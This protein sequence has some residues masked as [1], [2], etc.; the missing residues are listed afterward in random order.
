VFLDTFF[1]FNR[2][3]TNQFYISLSM[4]DFAM[5]T[6]GTAFDPLDIAA[7]SG[8]ADPIVAILAL[9]KELWLIGTLTTEVWQGTGAADFYFQLVQGAYIQHGCIAPFTATNQDVLGFW[10]MQDKDGKNIVVQGANYEL[11]II[12]TPYLTKEFNSYETTADAIGF[13]FQLDDH[14]FYALTFPTGNK[15]WLYDLTTEQWAEWS[16][17]MLMMVHLIV[18][19]PMGLFSLTIKTILVI[20]KMVTFTH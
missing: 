11:K 7:K 8:S 10:L 14:A 4:A 6:G 1:V 5:L 20:E 12:S 3:A 15:T 13:T 18:I 2:P 17:L 16:W 19:G 9:H